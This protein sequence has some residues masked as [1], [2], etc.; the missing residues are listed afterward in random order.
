MQQIGFVVMLGGIID[1]KG[2]IKAVS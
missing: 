2:K 1:D